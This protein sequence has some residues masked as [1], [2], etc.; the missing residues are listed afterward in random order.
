MVQRDRLTGKISAQEEKMAKLKQTALQQAKEG[1]KDQAMYT[2]Q[3]V[4]RIK[5]F[6]NNLTKRLE[7]MDKQVDNIESA[8]DDVSFTQ[9]LK[10][11]N[12]VIQQ[13]NQEIDLDEIRLAKELQQEQKMRQD[14]FDQLLDD[15]DDEDLKEEMA[16]IESELYR[17]NFSNVNIGESKTPAQKQPEKAQKTQNSERQAEMLLS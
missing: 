15:S 12:Q 5:E 2:V 4:K 11:S 16:K 8:M 1:N 6:K 10:E 3:K 13:L 9:V 17:E 14:E 7:F